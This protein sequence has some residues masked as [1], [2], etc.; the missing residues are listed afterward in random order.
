MLLNRT[1]DVNFTQEGIYIS[2]NDALDQPGQWS[3]PRRI[4][5]GGLWYPQVMGL[6]TGDSDKSAGQVARLFLSG[7]SSY[8]IQFQR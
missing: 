3:E 5:E 7:S 8:F 1:S 4:L 2:F 6:A